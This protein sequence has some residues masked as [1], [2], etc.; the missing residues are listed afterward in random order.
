MELH[1]EYPTPEQVVAIYENF[2]KNGSCFHN[3]L[4]D[5]TYKGFEQIVPYLDSEFRKL[6]YTG[7]RLA[8]FG[9]YKNLWGTVVWIEDPALEDYEANKELIDFY[10]EKN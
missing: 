1:V 10:M 3:E 2:I 8:L 5:Y 4:N 9:L 6:G 7:A